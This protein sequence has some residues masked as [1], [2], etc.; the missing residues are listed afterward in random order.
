MWSLVLIQPLVQAEDTPNH[1]VQFFSSADATKA[2]GMKNTLEL[3]G[4]PAFVYVNEVATS[5]TYYQV[6]VG[7]FA[8][9]D[10]AL[11]IKQRVVKKYPQF[12]FL[13]EAFLKTSP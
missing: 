2:E 3:Q 8:T 5:K 11:D 9:R 6:Q 7:P 12:N 10:L 13:N 4:Y 1:F